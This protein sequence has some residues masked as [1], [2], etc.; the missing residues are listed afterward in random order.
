[1]LFLRWS[2]DR[3]PGTCRSSKL[4]GRLS[5]CRMKLPKRLFRQFTLKWKPTRFALYLPREGSS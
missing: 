5:D 1:M 2:S 4:A 3:V